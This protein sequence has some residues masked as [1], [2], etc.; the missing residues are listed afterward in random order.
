MNTGNV[1]GEKKI[2]RA[3]SVFFRVKLLAIVLIVIL[4]GVALYSALAMNTIGDNLEAVAND[5]LP[6]LQA[7][8]T[9]EIELLSQE[10][11]AEKLARAANI[12]K[13]NANIA[14]LEKEV[15]AFNDRID[16]AFK[17]GKKVA[18][19]AA[20][21]GDSDTKAEA[22]KALKHFETLEQSVKHFHQA[23]E[24]LMAK[25]NARDMANAA[26][27]AE[28]MDKEGE[29]IAH[30]ADGFRKELSSFTDAKAHEALQ[31]EH[32]ALIVLIVC[33]LLG[34]LIGGL[35]AYVIL[36]GLKRSLGG[37]PAYIRDIMQRVAAGDLSVTLNT[38]AA[39]KESMAVAIKIMI[40]KLAQLIAET[41]SVVGAAAQGDLKRRIDLEGKQGFSL[42]LSNSVNQLAETSATVMG[43]VGNVL[44]RMAEG[45]LSSRAGSNYEGDFKR[46][47][48]AL[49]TTLTTLELVIGETQSV[50]GAASHGDLNQR[51]DLVGK[52]GFTLELANSVN[53]LAETSAKVLGDVGGVLT[54]MAEGDFSQRVKSDYEGDFK[55]LADALNQTLDK[56]GMTLEEVRTGA[57]NITAASGQVSATAQS[58]SQATSEQAASLEETTTAVE[59]MSASIAQNTENARVTDGIA[60]QSSEDAKKGG[61]AVS[62]T[63]AAMKAIAEKISIIDDI[64]YRTDLLALNAAIEAARAGEHGMGFAVVAAEVRKLAERSQVAAQEIGELAAGSVKTAEDAGTLLLT[65][66]PSIQ[67]TADLV[68]EITFSSNE[69]STGAGQISTAMSQLNTITQQNASGSEEL[70]ATAEEMNGQALSLQELVDQFK[71][72]NR[73]AP[74]NIGKQ[75]PRKTNSTKPSVSNI[76]K[77]PANNFDDFEQF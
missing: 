75:A 53:Q 64:A 27:L 5:D 52:K 22:V 63:V 39:D 10:L 51:I 70:S 59:Q 58:L 40:G 18:E 19:H 3:E 9:I 61:E 16:A 25:I 57:D 60:K 56:L 17:E 77:N 72:A 69:Q 42:D 24:N 73:T 26:H 36:A 43:D 48:D 4:T 65:M 41:Q 76:V 55:A 33:G 54:V 13:P 8:N 34:L 47:A 31:S 2:S 67:K 38:Q 37:E 20:R 71:L 1:A 7:I 45:D 15:R 23:Q 30:D 35:L 21:I 66:L 29:D 11:A 50:V 44:G 32:R 12:Q 68:R 74:R 6:M 49:N 62:A 28:V 46:L 14:V